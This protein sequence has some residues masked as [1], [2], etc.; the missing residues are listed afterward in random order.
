MPEKSLHH[1]D[2]G[3]IRYDNSSESLQCTGDHGIAIGL[4]FKD[5][6]ENFLA[7]LLILVNESFR[8]D[9]QIVFGIMLGVLK[10]PRRRA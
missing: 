7:D 6:F 5:I 1:H 9:D 4:A 10:P 3:T 2:D 8:I